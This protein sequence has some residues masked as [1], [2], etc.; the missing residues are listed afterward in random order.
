MTTITE[1]ESEVFAIAHRFE[2]FT[3]QF[4]WG[5]S[6]S[7]V[8]DPIE[9][10]WR[11]YNVAFAVASHRLLRASIAV[12]GAGLVME[13]LL[14][15]RTHLELLGIQRYLESDKQRVVTFAERGARR[16]QQLVE[17]ARR[18]GHGDA[19]DWSA[20]ASRASRDINR[21]KAYT[22]EIEFRD[23]AE[24]MLKSTA[25]KTDIEGVLRVA[26]NWV[27]MNGAALD[28]YADVDSDG[29]LTVEI[30]PDTQGAKMLLSAVRY[31]YA[32]VSV[33]NEVLGLGQEATLEELWTQFRSTYGDAPEDSLTQ[34]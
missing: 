21:L 13:T 6:L 2:A 18:L 3:A 32:I 17:R 34:E 33:A 28:F 14:P 30:H 27:H 8:T 16:Q 31:H 9:N 29:R 1:N 23:R 19:D 15:L 24:E 20:L 12:M 11:Y 22:A 26:D 4:P 25:F 5:G 7:H 10:L